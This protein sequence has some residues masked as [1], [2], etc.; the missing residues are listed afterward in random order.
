MHFLAAKVRQA[1]EQCGN[2][3]STHQMFC[4]DRRKQVHEMQW[5]WIESF[6]INVV[7]VIVIV[8]VAVAT[9]SRLFY[10]QFAVSKAESMEEEKNENPRSFHVITNVNWSRLRGIKQLIRMNRAIRFTSHEIKIDF[11]NSLSECARRCYW[12]KMENWKWGQAHVSNWDKFECEKK[13]VEN[14]LIG[15][16]G[17]QT[18]RISTMWNA[19]SGV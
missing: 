8:V 11:L 18:T 6:V 2:G 9:R 10:V 1:N 13:Y 19:S 14:G 7:V 4:V 5:N 15:V 16:P 17:N 12:N 3:S